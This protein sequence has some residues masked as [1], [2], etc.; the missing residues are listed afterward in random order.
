[1][2]AVRVGE[3]TFWTYDCSRRIPPFAIASI[4]GV[5][6]RE[7]VVN[8]ASDQPW[9]SITENTMCGCFF[10]VTAN[11]EEIAQKSSIIS[12]QHSNTCTQRAMAP[13]RLVI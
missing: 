6:A 11:A 3:Q 7:R 2:I 12:M 10:E 4:V 5:C 8:P 13:S 9:S 1:M